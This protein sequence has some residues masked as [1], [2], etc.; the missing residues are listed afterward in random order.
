MASID[1]TR[2]DNIYKLLSSNVAVKFLI[3][4]FFPEADY[5]NEN[6]WIDVHDKKVMSL[7]KLPRNGLL[8]YNN[9]KSLTTHSNEAYGTT[10]L[11]WL[12]VMCSDYLH[13]HEIP[14]GT[15]IALPVL[16][17]IQ[18]AFKEI[19]TGLRNQVVTI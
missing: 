10:T 19:Y 7:L 1:Q 18:S 8:T 5:G 14:T 15:L 4:E 12:I 2:Q 6:I 17:D 16:S 9:S 11:W 13:P 3:E